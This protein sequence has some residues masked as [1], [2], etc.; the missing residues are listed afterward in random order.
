MPATHAKRETR[1]DDIRQAEA[2]DRHAA[3]ECENHL[4]KWYDDVRYPARLRVN[5]G[6]K[7]KL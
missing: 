6:V 5:A 1:T 4:D 3:A 7:E 2:L